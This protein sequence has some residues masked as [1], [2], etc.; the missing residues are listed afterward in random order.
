MQQDRLS[1]KQ[2]KVQRKSKHAKSSLSQQRLEAELEMLHSEA[3]GK[4]PLVWHALANFVDIL[5]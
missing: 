1:R 3:Q 2:K 4:D 5:E